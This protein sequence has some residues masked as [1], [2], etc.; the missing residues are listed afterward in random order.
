[1]IRL[2]G[3]ILA[4]LLVSPVA[5]QSTGAGGGGGTP[6][7]SSGQ[8]QYNSSGAFAGS[9]AVTVLNPTTA[10]DLILGTA[11]TTTGTLSLFAGAGAINL[12]GTSGA[13]GTA[14]F[15]VN[16]GTV[17]ELNFAQS[18]TAVQ[19]YTQQITESVATGTAPFSITSTT[20][21]PNLNVAQLSPINLGVS[22]TA[23][24]VSAG[25]IFGTGP[26]ITANGS[27]T[28]NITVGTSP[29]ATI[30]SIV[31]PTATGGWHCT[32]D[33]ITTLTEV[34]HQTASSVTGASLN[35]YAITT[36]LATAPAAGDHILLT[37]TAY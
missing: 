28:A 4:L 13:G 2:W 15:P 7:G 1:M 35:A 9:P 3:L 8:V 16:T 26:A 21:V 23:I 19:S 37:C 29:A 32:G 12:Q 14:T 18:W 22:S 17:A 20:R 25:G 31:L 5:A 36:G 24:T 30:G 34:I 33:D 10:P 27:L 11:S 6:G